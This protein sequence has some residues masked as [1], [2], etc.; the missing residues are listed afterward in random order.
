MNSYSIKNIITFRKLDWD[1]SEDFLYTTDISEVFEPFIMK[2]DYY[3]YGLLDSGGMQIEIDNNKF[4]INSSSLLVY[5]PDQTLKILEIAPE[6]KGAFVLFTRKFVDSLS[7]SFLSIVPHSF[8]RSQFGSHITLSDSDHAKMSSLFGKTIEFLDASETKTDRWMYS[9]K[10]ILLALIN[11]SDFLLDKYKPVVY[12][13]TAREVQI[14]NEFKKLVVLN[15]AN[16]R[17][18]EFYAEKLNVSRNY[19]HKIIKKLC[20]QTPFEIINNKVLSE[21]KALLSYSDNT[22][23][24]IAEM[25]AFGSI[26]SFSKYF[27]KQTG[28][29]PSLFRITISS[30]QIP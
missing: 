25:M 9:A 10:N 14:N 13:S 19:L 30:V 15:Y 27:K 1:I 23:G 17:G 22:I 29:S 26:Q 18:L 6:T 8:L 21:C 11:E 16:Q 2:P 4:H 7:E 5:R 12:E 28:K 3:S 24:E 20:N